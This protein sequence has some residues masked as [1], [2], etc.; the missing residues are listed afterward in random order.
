MQVIYCE[1]WSQ[2]A[3]TDKGGS[4]IQK[5]EINTGALIVSYHWE[6]LRLHPAGGIWDT[7][8]PEGWGNQAVYQLLSV[9]SR[10][11]LP[12]CNFQCL[13]RWAE[14]PSAAK[15]SLQ[16]VDSYHEKLWGCKGPWQHLPSRFIELSSELSILVMDAFKLIAR[17]KREYQQA[18]IWQYVKVR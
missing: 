4:E 10:E 15:D 11:M 8:E 13:G 3:L 5:R 6:Q 14:H 16:T 12:R 17:E 9:I 7:V 18:S 2:K 1:S